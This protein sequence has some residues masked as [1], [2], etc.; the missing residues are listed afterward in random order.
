MTLPGV[1]ERFRAA[2][3]EA[4]RPY[5]P[6]P[7]GGRVLEIGGGSGFQAAAMTDWGYR[8]ESV[9][10]QLGAGVGRY[11]PITMY[12]GT[13][14]PFPDRS[15]DLVFS[16]NVL[17]HVHRLDELLGEMRR[18]LKPGGTMIHI[19]P[20]AVWR[21]WT[22]AAHYPWLVRTLVSGRTTLAGIDATPVGDVVARRGF[23]RTIGRVLLAP[24][25]GEHVATAFGELRS[26]SRR[27][28]ES[29]F[30]RLESFSVEHHD[31]GLFYT[32]YT[33]LPGAGIDRRRRLAALLGSSCH[34]FVLR[35]AA[36]A[37]SII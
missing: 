37:A 4:A 11:H 16:S 12:D 14:L 1:L 31:T 5:F 24:P 27:R 22:S 18:V 21:L 35:S 30:A 23:W 17:E 10:V 34:L 3:L 33:L 25:H 13:H 6:K 29:Q 19:V 15:F 9:D 2:E 28:W 7:P 32:G 8:V 36:E 20:S 26:F